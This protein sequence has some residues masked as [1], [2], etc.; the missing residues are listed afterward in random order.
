MTEREQQAYELGFRDGL[1]TYSWMKDGTTW[2]G[3]C[4]TTLKDAQ[5]PTR[6]TKHWNFGNSLYILDEN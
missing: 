3:T 1:A 5:S 2:V 4:G 6:L